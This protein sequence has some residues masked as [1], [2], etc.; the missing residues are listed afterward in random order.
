VPIQIRTNWP[1]DLAAEGLVL[2]AT[3]HLEPALGWDFNRPGDYSWG[4]TIDYSVVCPAGEPATAASHL[5]LWKT[6]R[7][8]PLWAEL[9]ANNLGDGKAADERLSWERGRYRLTELNVL[10]P[11]PSAE[12]SRLRHFEVVAACSPRYE[13]PGGPGSWGLSYA[14]REKPPTPEDLG[15][16]ILRRPGQQYGNEHE[17]E[18]GHDYWSTTASGFEA[19]PGQVNSWSIPLPEPL[20]AA[21]R[22]SLAA[23]R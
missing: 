11:R 18:L 12:G 21:V 16:G 6:E 22:A 13:K 23:S 15:S 10:R 3:F 5:Y 20:I 8:A 17:L 4:G 19:R 2:N 14:L 7:S 9:L 1:A